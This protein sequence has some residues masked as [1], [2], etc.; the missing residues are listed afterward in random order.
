MFAFAQ[1]QFALHVDGCSHLCYI[2]ACAATFYDLGARESWPS[3]IRLLIDVLLSAQISSAT[4][5]LKRTM[6]LD[7]SDADVHETRTLA[8]KLWSQCE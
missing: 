6:A 8:Q 3:K 1:P 4:E 5:A 2:C 7:N